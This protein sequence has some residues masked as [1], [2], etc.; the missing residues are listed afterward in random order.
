MR[1]AHEPS[2]TPMFGLC[3]GELEEKQSGVGGVVKPERLVLATSVSG[4][5]ATPGGGAVSRQ[6]DREFPPPRGWRENVEASRKL[7]TRILLPIW[8]APLNGAPVGKKSCREVRRVSPQH[9]PLCSFQAQQ[10][11]LFLSL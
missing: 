3:H 7:P 4:A 9:L 2:T 5:Q 8:L 10:V 1:A 11:T 6:L